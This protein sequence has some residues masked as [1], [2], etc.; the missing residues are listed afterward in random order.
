MGPTTYATVVRQPVRRVSDWR[1]I[2]SLCYRQSGVGATVGLHAGE[3][4]FPTSPGN[5]S[6]DRPWSGTCWGTN[7]KLPRGTLQGKLVHSFARITEPKKNDD[8]GYKTGQNLPLIPLLI[9]R[10]S[11]PCAH[12]ICL[13]TSILLRP[14]SLS[15]RPTGTRLRV[16][17]WHTPR[18]SSRSTRTRN[19][20]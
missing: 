5:L 16:A 11:P 6:S 12:S 3:Y 18:L 4:M 7:F 8:D 19:R 10:F 20:M 2:G 9:D 14:P 17:S 13:W 1:A 15:G